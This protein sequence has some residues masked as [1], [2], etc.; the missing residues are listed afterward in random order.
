MG[1]KNRRQPSPAESSG[2]PS[3]FGPQTTE[4]HGYGEWVVRRITGAGATKTYR[5]PGCDQEIRPATPHVVAFPADDYGNV[6]DRRHWHTPCW[7]ARGRR[8]PRTQKSSRGPR[9]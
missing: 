3:V 4:E 5:C 9:Y 8:G 2:G 6:E 1:R 7:Q